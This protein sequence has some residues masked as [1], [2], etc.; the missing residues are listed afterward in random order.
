[1]EKFIVEILHCDLEMKTVKGEN[2]EKN[3]KVPWKNNL[4]N[5]QE[6]YIFT[7]CQR[8]LD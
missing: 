1:M 4:S 5:Q 2:E 6:Y 7:P 3:G 8:G